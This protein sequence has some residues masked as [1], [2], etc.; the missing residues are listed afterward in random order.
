[1]KNKRPGQGGVATKMRRTKAASSSSPRALA[2]T[3]FDALDAETMNET[4]KTMMPSGGQA[5]GTRPTTIVRNANRQPKRRA[6]EF[7]S[8]LSV[9]VTRYVVHTSAMR[10]H[11]ANPAIT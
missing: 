4:V 1:T 10:E 6:N 11:T 2:M 9:G 5:Y 7:A 8:S 3:I